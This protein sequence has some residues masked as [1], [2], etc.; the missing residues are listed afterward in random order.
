MYILSDILLVKHL[1]WPEKVICILSSILPKSSNCILNAILCHLHE[2]FQ[3]SFLSSSS[4]A[5]QLW[6][7]TKATLF[8]SSV[9]KTEGKIRYDF[10][11]WDC[12]LIPILFLLWNGATEIVLNL[13][14][15]FRK[16]FLI[17]RRHLREDY[18]QSG[19]QVLWVVLVSKYISMFIYFA[20]K[21][22]DLKV[23]PP[24]L[25][26]WPMTSETDVGN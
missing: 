2:T 22:A 4:Q 20:Y 8:F 14:L 21:R 7:S 1:F 16:T 5:V 26:S 24:I 19:E 23:L 25:L 9:G 6:N 10:S 15:S 17:S 3:R 13:R 12:K 11:Y 18:R